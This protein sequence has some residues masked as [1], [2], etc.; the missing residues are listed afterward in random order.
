MAGVKIF[1]FNKASAFISPKTS[2]NKG[3]TIT[4]KLISCSIN[5][6]FKRDFQVYILW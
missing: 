6:I 3:C 5:S 1:I 2:V 4:R